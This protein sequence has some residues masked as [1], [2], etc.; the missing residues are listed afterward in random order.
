M[1][2]T[3]R[4]GHLARR[5]AIGLGV[6][7]LALVIAVPATSAATAKT[8]LA[9]IRSNGTQGNGNSE[10]AS[11]SGDGRYVAFESY[12]TRLV[13]NDTN[14]ERDIF[15]HDRKTGKT[16]RVSIRSNGT[17]GNNGSYDPSISGNGRYVAFES[18]ATNLVQNDTNGMEDVFL[19]DRK[20]G[21]TTRVSKRSN[22]TQGNGESVYVSISG[23][24]RY[25]AFESDASNLVKNDT[26]D[27][28]DVFQRGPIH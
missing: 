15:V 14:G 26:N 4:H 3:T 21:K 22:G 18:A 8:K 28:E 5:T 11:I 23:N 12:A 13:H 7:L 25:V 1:P 6:A 9:S 20:T 19:H 2:R 10:N 17:Q 24:G 16:T 27:D